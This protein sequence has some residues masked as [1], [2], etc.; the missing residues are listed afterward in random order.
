MGPGLEAQ[1]VL[2]TQPGVIVTE[3]GGFGAPATAAIRGA[4]AADTPV[5]LAGVRLNDDVGGTADL[6]L[7]PLW[8]VDRVEVYRGNAPLEADRLG[9]G[10]AIF[11]EP[12]MPTRDGGGVGYWGGSWGASK[13]WAYQGVSAGPVRALVGVSGDRAS[14]RYPF[15]NDR[16]ELFEPGVAT[17]ALRENADEATTEGWGI[18]H[19]DLGAGAGVD[20]LCNGIVREQG[21]PSLRGASSRRRRAS[22][23]TGPS[24]RSRCTP[25][26]TTTARRSTRRRRCSWDAPP[27]TIRGSSLDLADTAPLQIV[28]LRVEQS[29]AATLDAADWLLVRPRVDVAHEGVERDPDNIPLGRARREFGRAAVGAEARVTPWLGA[30]A[31]ANGECH[32]TGA[33]PTRTCDV[34][35]PTGR[36]GLDAGGRRLHVLANVGRYVRVPTLAEVYGASGNVHGNRALVP[37]SGYTADVGV[38]AQTGRGAIVYGAYVDAF[39]FGHWVEQLVAYERTGQGFV[40]PYNVGQ[41]QVLGAE[42][43]A[44]VAPVKGVRAEVTATLLDPR[45]TTPGRT[46]VNDVLPFRSRLVGGPRVR[47]DWKRPSRSALSVVGGE[48]AAPSTSRAATPAR[49]ASGSSRSRPAST[50]RPTPSGSAAGSPRAFASRTSSTPLARTSS[51]IRSP[52]GAPISDWRQH[53][54]EAWQ[55]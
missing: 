11:F 55:S 53:G 34:L 22:T 12:R 6:S 44:G 9:A 29:L 15:V 19:V 18:A 4:T 25:R 17:S 3:S 33:D 49:P 39:V 30:H 54:E 41:A 31:L 1:D 27:S 42:L 14:N 50:S 7:V 48:I 35:E 45:D 37:E 10:G 13:G 46:T 47:G 52:D 20:V 21:V 36:V 8:L 2:R 43:L 28:G 51:V 38:R 26:S 40:T 24:P 5:Y 16:G 32:D 23:P